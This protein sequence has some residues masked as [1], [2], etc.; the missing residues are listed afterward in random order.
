MVDWVR[1]KKLPAGAVCEVVQRGPAGATV[2]LNERGVAALFDEV[3]AAEWTETFEAKERKN[4]KTKKPIPPKRIEKREVKGRDGKESIEKRFV[5]DSVV[6]KGAFLADK[7]RSEGKLWTKLWRDMLWSTLRGVPA[8]RRPYEARADKATCRD[9]AEAW[10]QLGTPDDTVELPSTYY[11]GA[12]AHSAELVPFRDAARL[13]F[14]LHCWPFA[15]QVYQPAMLDN[16]GES[17]FVGYAVAIPD[18]SDLATFCEELPCILEARG[19][20]PRAYRPREA[21]IEV[22]A[23]GALDLLCRVRR[24]L[25]ARAARAST[26]DLVLGVDV[27]HLTKRGN[28]VVVLG[29]ARVEPSGELLDEY[30]RVAKAY[31]SDL[32]RATRL[33]NVVERRTWFAGFDAL[34]ETRPRSLTQESRWFCADA[35]RAFEGELMS[36][37]DKGLRTPEVLVYDFVRGYVYGKLEAKHGLTWDAVKGDDSRRAEY[38]QKKNAIAKDAFL[39]VRSRTGEDFVAYFAGALASTPHRLSQEEFSALAHALRERT[40]DVRTLTLLALS[41]HS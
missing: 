12:M 1:R 3:Y 34:F 28:N 32:F 22:V 19:S 15:S 8:T 17:Q 29:A 40:E 35:R 25:A 4:K 9:S 10:E 21:V 6:P 16:D 36:G 26:S 33:R 18:V 41:A 20:E 27:I 14:L 7:D 13:Q 30:E 39:A 5:Y 24:R 23:E 2:R 38:D 11:V 31:R 37:N